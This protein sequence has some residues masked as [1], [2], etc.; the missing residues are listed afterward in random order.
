MLSNLEQLDKSRGENLPVITTDTKIRKNSMRLYTY[1]VCLSRFTKPN[2]PRKFFQ[3]DFTLN[4]IK[5]DLNMNYNTIKKY[6]KVLEETGL[7]RYHGRDRQEGDFFFWDET[8]MERKKYPLGYYEL[9]KEKSRYRIIPRETLDKIRKEFAVNEMELKLYLFL[10]NLQEQYLYLGYEEAKFTISE[11]RQLMGFKNDAKVNKR[12]YLSLI[13]LMK[14]NLVK[15]KIKTKKIENF[16]EE[17]TYFVIEKVNYYTDGGEARKII[18]EC[19]G[20]IPESVKKRLLNSE[21]IVKFE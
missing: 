5:K 21:P 17:M 2:E 13:W 12:I 7:V 6:W 15:A 4:Q 11:A 19:D 18:K 1:L 16:N 3:S 9:K 10:A 20:I 8:F 14:L